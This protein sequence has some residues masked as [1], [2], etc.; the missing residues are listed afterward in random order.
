MLGDVVLDA[1]FCQR[2]H[3]DD[4]RQRGE[5]EGRPEHRDRRDEVQ[6][7]QPGDEVFNG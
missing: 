7:G 5:Q 1:S 4:E 6:G 3:E 2:A